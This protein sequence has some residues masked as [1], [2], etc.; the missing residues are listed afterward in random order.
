MTSIPDRLF[1][2]HEDIRSV[3]VVDKA[4]RLVDSRSRA[5]H[6]VPKEFAQ[7]LASTWISTVGAL[8][9]RTQDYS[10]EI[11]FL[12][13]KYSRFHLYGFISK[14]SYVVLTARTTLQ[15]DVI[16]RISASLSPRP[17]LFTI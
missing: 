16:D 10:G 5:K 7:G 15:P 1:A 3:I 6:P 8:V 17:L 9:E 14:D 4:G 11:S 13:I 12:Q 2:L